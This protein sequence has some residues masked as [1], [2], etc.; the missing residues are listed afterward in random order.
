VLVQWSKEESPA[1]SIEREVEKFRDYWLAQPGQKGVKA[2]WERTWRNWIRRNA[3][4]GQKPSGNKRG[5]VG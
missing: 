3:E 5:F 4:S 2:D 1:L